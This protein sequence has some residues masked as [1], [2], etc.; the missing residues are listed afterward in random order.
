M[1][2]TGHVLVDVMAIF[3]LALLSG[4]VVVTVAATIAVRRVHR[5][6]RSWRRR[7]VA[8]LQEAGWV[9]TEPV[10]GG[11][12]VTA[13]VL[14]SAA[15]LARPQWWAVQQSRRGMWRAV[16]AARHSVGVAGR[17]GAPV[18]DLPTLV[19]QLE[20]AARS[21]DAL[22]RADAGRADGSRSHHR[23]VRQVEEAALQVHEA[24][25][26]SLHS[27]AVAESDVLLPAVRLEVAALAAGVR[28]A[29][30]SRRPA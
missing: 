21:A 18:G 13:A 22:A 10:T 27:V 19:A 29:T 30:A 12:V 1:Q 23:E 14:A 5:R 3:G 6:W 4:V 25:V 26:A 15:H 7:G 16:A 17:A 9:R 8:R 11:P 24:A 20:L 2:A 28:A